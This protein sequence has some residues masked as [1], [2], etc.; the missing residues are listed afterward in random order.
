MS[1]D[2]RLQ[3][4]DATVLSQAFLDAS[5]DNLVNNLELIVDIEK[6]GGGFIRASDRNKYVVT[7]GVGVFYEA[8]LVFPIIKRTVGDF[9]SPTLEFS[10]LELTLS[11]VDGRLNQYLPAGDDFTGWIGKS[12]TVKLGLGELASTYKTIFNGFITDQGGFKRGVS[13]ITMTARDRFEG[14]NQVFPT[15]IFTKTAY[16]NLEGD[17]ENIPVPL[18]Y[19]DWTVEVEPNMASVPA[20]PVNG[21]DPDV[22]GDTSNTNNVQLVIANHALVSFDSAN[23]YLKRGEKAWLVPSADI[24]AVSIGGTPS[25][26][27]IVQAAGTMTAITPDTDDQQLEFGRGDEFYVRVKGKALPGGLDDNPVVQAKEILKEFGG[28][29]DGDFHAN[30]ATYA[31]KNTPAVSA[32]ANIKTRVWVQDPENV[33]EFALSLL[34]QVRIEA[35]IDRDLKFKLLALHLEDFDATPDFTV[36]NWDVEL[37]SLKLSIDDRTNFNRAQ[38]VF[39]YLPNRKENYKDTKIYKNTAAITQ[40]GKA[41]SK[42]VVFPNIY[43]ETDAINQLK[44]TLRITSAYL[45]NVEVTLTWRS[46]LLDIGDFVKLNIKIQSSEFENVPALIREVG[47]DPAG[48]KIPLKLWSCQMLPFTGY[49]PGYS[50]TVGGSTAVIDEE[51]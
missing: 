3:Y 27:E 37:G 36:R 46:M 11:N 43:T 16:P 2:Q 17:K 39:N 34:E 45:E 24:T 12:V 42:K 38:A 9:Q 8:L 23:V 51:T 50:G 47:Y 7:G 5:Q 21:E 41:I 49:E 29:V 48:I 10:Q 22:N 6:P 35:F 20:V 1:N 19:G 18:V 4:E 28:L 30:W 33:L 44:E 15:Q 13:S 31:A 40:S 14:V 32:I 26:F 25:S